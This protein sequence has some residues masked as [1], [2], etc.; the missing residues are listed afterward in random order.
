MSPRA[1]RPRSY[2]REFLVA[3]DER[4]VAAAEVEQLL[5]RTALDEAAAVEDDD[6]VGVADGREAVRDRDRRPSLS[7]PVERVLHGPLGLRVERAR[8][9]VQDEHPRGAA[10]APPP[11]RA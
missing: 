5:V 7:Q 4:G 8:R 1:S 10:G 3:R 6:L 9:L 11:P 2:P